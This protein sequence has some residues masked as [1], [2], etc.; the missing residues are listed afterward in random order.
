MLMKF[1]GSAR[2][3]FMRHKVMLFGASIV[4]VVVSLIIFIAQGLN[5]GIDFKGGVLIE[6]QV[7]EDVRISDIRGKLSDLDFGNIK[8]QE[9]GRSDIFLL[10]MQSPEGGAKAQQEMI[11][12]IKTILGDD[13]VEYR[14]TESVGPTFSKELRNS[15]LLAIG[16]TL[17]GIFVYI[18][19]RFEWQFGLG[20][21]LALMHDIIFT[22]G[23]FSL[24]QL[25][26]SVATVAAVL[27]IAGYSINDTVV[28]Y[29]RVR[30]NLRKYKNLPLDEIYNL[31]L[32][33]TLSRTL[34]TSLTTLLALLALYI[35]GGEVVREFV[36]PLIW[37]ILIGTYSSTG[38]AVPFV[39]YFPPHTDDGEKTGP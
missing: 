8:I 37:G 27:T 14:R 25:E 7:V 20:A 4:F 34:M 6:T 9:F 24:L 16:L 15:A 17:L 22:I 18:W 1:F 13:V 3:D 35:L 11:T 31:S 39:H 30:E 32:N 21:V 2:I 28:I 26:V 5:L 33:Q 12:R 38:F 10:R 19:F 36:L 23:L 29:D